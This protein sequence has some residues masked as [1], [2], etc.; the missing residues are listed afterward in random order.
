M[1]VLGPQVEEALFA[2]GNSQKQLAL[3]DMETITSSSR[4]NQKNLE[5]N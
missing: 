1:L 2:I 5:L 3:E 4:L